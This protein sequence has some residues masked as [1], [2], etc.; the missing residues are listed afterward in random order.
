V[1]NIIHAEGVKRLAR[2][3]IRAICP[4]R[5]RAG[6]QIAVETNQEPFGARQTDD[7]HCMGPL[8]LGN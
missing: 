2:A 3:K 8:C 6:V 1:I 5:M 4:E 7:V